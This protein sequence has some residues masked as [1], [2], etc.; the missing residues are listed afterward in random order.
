MQADRPF[1]TVLIP[2]YRRCDLLP[3]AVSSVLTQSWTN[4]ELVVVDDASPD[5][6]AEV[7]ARIDDPRVR[8]LRRA[9]NGGAAATRNS[10]IEVA[11]GSWIS[12]LDDDD[13]YDPEFLARTR[14]VLAGAPPTVGLTWCG[15]RW[16]RDRDGE[17]EVLRE[18]LWQ[19]TYRDREHAYRSFL[20]SRRIGTNCGITLRRDAVAEVGGFD[21]TFRGGAED[22]D[23][24]I[25]M[26]RR[27]D[28]RVVPEVLV[29]VHL[30]G[31]P[32]LRGV[33]L[34]KARDYEKILAKHASTLTADRGLAADLHYKTGW[35][36]YQAGDRRR[37]R[38]HLLAS[39]RRRPFHRA[40]SALLLYEILGR[41]AADAHRAM[42]QMRRGHAPLSDVERS[43]PS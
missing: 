31:G 15:I 17:R 43:E 32:N 42:S 14:E 21:E 6:T 2:T 27:F 29:D 37:G 35:L 36:F 19:P 39:I 20:R 41:R 4:F 22:T 24:L 18:E 23:F 34:E 11:R 16:L 1:F 8:Y 10:G 33:S 30:H 5:A 25:R 9:E 13:E 12:L 28:F 40:W 26:V 38:R 3:R 7:M